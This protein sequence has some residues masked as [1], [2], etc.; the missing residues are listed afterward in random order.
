MTIIPISL[1]SLLLRGFFDL[2]EEHKALQPD[3]I[4]KVY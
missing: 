3:L 4:Q 1:I 2:M